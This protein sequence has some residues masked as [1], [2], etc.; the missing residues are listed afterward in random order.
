MVIDLC[1]V[2]DTS[3][4]RSTVEEGVSKFPR[5]YDELKFEIQVIYMCTIKKK[6]TFVWQDGNVGS[7]LQKCP[8]R[9]EQT[10]ENI[11]YA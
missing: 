7:G 1:P 3:T 11:S 9:D 5:G 2:R 8:V 6:K 4:S 10:F